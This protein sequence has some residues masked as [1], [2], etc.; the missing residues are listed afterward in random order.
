MTESKGF[1]RTVTPV[2]RSC[3]AGTLEGGRHLRG[4]TMTQGCDLKVT[5]GGQEAL[6]A[7]AIGTADEIRSAA[8]V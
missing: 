3:A 1:C 5:T 7:S 6:V 4:R 2:F 8:T